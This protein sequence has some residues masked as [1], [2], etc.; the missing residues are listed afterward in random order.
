MKFLS[1]TG[2][3]NKINASHAFYLRE[4]GILSQF[5]FVNWLQVASS[6]QPA[7]KVGECAAKS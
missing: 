7:K 4:L 2:H 1:P 5:W 3:K 6:N